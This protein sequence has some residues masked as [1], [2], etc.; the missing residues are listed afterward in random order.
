MI[1]QKNEPL[2]AEEI[3]RLSNLKGVSALLSEL[4]SK[5]QAA[6][7][8]K[9]EIREFLNNSLDAVHKQT[10]GSL[11]PGQQFRISPRS[12]GAVYVRMA[13]EKINQIGY[14]HLITDFPDK[15]HFYALPDLMVYPVK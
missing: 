7:A 14:R 2:P 6:G 12:I 8:T 3:A 11:E 15:P 1:I 9:E 13:D 4:V 10:I 5:L